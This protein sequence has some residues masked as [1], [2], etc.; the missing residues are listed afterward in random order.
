MA[1]YILSDEQLN[2][3]ADW[4]LKS[5]AGTVLD[6]TFLEYLE[7]RDYYDDLFDALQDGAALHRLPDGRQEIIG[8]HGIMQHVGAY[9]NTP[10]GRDSFPA[11]THQMEAN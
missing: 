10:V 5:R 3:L 8:N 6:I 4:F 2:E 7:N 11:I 9:G 1:K